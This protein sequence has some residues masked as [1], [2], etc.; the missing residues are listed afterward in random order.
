[1]ILIPNIDSYLFDIRQ[2]VMVKMN[3]KRKN[4]VDLKLTNGFVKKIN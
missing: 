3:S 2:E 1:M 4:Q